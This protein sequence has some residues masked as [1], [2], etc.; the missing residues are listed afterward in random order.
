MWPG[1]SSDGL[2]QQRRGKHRHLDETLEALIAEQV[3][4]LLVG[5]GDENRPKPRV[6]VVGEGGLD[7]GAEGLIS[8]VL[9]GQALDVL[10]G[11]SHEFLDEE[12]V[13]HAPGLYMTDQRL[14]GVLVG[15]VYVVEILE[16]ILHGVGIVVVQHDTVFFR[17]L[18]QFDENL[19]V[20]CFS[21]V[22]RIAL[23]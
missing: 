13:S 4:L 20:R 15:I 21:F 22:S 12:L 14:I 16:H 8:T 6:N 11:M 18:L 1:V 7:G 17:F 5:D 3:G 10:E 2:S 9:L 23:L 19:L